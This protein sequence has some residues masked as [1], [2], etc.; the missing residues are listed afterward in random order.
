MQSQGVHTWGD[1]GNPE[2]TD[3]RVC[4]R[5]LIIKYILVTSDDRLIAE[6]RLWIKEKDK[7]DKETCVHSETKRR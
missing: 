6:P 2:R 7:E 3:W 5:G 4:S 1:G